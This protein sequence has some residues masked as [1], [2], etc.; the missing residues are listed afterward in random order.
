MSEYRGFTTRCKPLVSLKHR[1][2]RLEFAKQHF[3][4]LLQLWNNILWTDETE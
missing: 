4:K 2:T 1:K 3:K